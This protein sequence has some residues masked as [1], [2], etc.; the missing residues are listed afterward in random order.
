MMRDIRSVA[1]NHGI[2]LFACKVFV[3]GDIPFPADVVY[4]AFRHRP[5]FRFR[6]FETVNGHPSVKIR[7]ILWVGEHLFRPP[8]P[9]L[10]ERVAEF[11]HLA[12][13]MERC[14]RRARVDMHA[15]FGIALVH[16]ANYRERGTSPLASELDCCPCQFQV[17]LD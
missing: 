15:P 8:F 7:C 13:D 10:E 11:R 2:A 4:Y 1:V 17:I 12:L 6:F 9:M 14:R 3:P 5:W 16:L